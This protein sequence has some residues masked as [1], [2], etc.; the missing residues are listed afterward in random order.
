VSSRPPTAS[1]VCQ[2]RSDPR[3]RLPANILPTRATSP[4]ELP[5]TGIRVP[6]ADQAESELSSA[7]AT[8]HLTAGVRA[9]GEHYRSPKER[10]PLRASLPDGRQQ[11]SDVAPDGLPLSGGAEA[12]RRRS[13]RADTTAWERSR[14][15]RHPLLVAL[16][17]R[18]RPELWRR[19]RGWQA[20]TLPQ[21]PLRRAEAARRRTPIR[22]AAGVPSQK[23][24]EARWGAARLL[25]RRMR[26]SAPTTE[27]TARHPSCTCVLPD[28]G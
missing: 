10:R 25:H 21:L 20:A 2:P 4:P 5:S 3:R 8:R 22:G 28:F 23:C 19:P 17:R 14:A 9:V 27:R 24:R 12:T 1:E 16:L 15:R 7:T 18:G 11:A 26:G 13:K 6:P